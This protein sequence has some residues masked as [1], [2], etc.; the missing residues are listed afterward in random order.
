MI[1]LAETSNEELQQFRANANATAGGCLGHT[2]GR[3]NDTLVW[4]F[5]RELERRGLSA[6]ETI[7]GVYNGKGSF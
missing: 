2:K 5:D 4:R 7:E 6:D 1:N 3:E